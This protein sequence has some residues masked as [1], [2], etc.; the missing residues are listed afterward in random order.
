MRIS[1]TIAKSAVMLAGALVMVLPFVF[2]Y[3]Q[4][5][6][7]PPSLLSLLAEGYWVYF[8]IGLVVMTVPLAVGYIIEH[9]RS[10]GDDEN[11]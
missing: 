11:Q 4:N 2:A 5:T 1:S 10:E 9:L 8:I 3:T 6:D 7:N